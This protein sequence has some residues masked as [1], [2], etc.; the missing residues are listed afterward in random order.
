MFY[1]L[2]QARFAVQVVQALSLVA[3]YIT[4]KQWIIL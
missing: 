1:S 2:Q 3:M 4:T